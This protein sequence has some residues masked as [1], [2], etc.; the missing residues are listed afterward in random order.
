VAPDPAKRPKSSYLR[1][2]AE[3]PNE[4]WQADFTHYP[5]ADGTGTEILC[6]IDDHSRYALHLTAHHRVTGP[7]V[8]A[9]FRAAVAAHG[10][11]APALTDIQAG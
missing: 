7:A 2:A 9:E 6:W 3:L 4:C 11:P 10:A 5:L 8:L 1:F